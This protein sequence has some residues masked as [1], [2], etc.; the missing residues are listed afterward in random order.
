ME[1]FCQLPS[2]RLV[3]RRHTLAV[4]V[5]ESIG[6]PILIKGIPYY[7]LSWQVKDWTGCLTSPWMRSSSMCF[8]PFS[9][10]LSQTRSSWTNQPVCV[11]TGLNEAPRALFIHSVKPVCWCREK[12]GFGCVGGRLHTALTQTRVR[13][14]IGYVSQT[15]QPL[16]AVMS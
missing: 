15:I 14:K 2:R 4:C 13:V 1:L 16:Q 9:S 10:R 6:K 12:T 3:F 5:T 7:G 8:P 11:V